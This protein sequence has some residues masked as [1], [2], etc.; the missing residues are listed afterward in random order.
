MDEAREGL[1]TVQAQRE[2]LAARVRFPWWYLAAYALGIAVI[3]AAPLATHFIPEVG[4]LVVLVA[5]GAI[6]LL[7]RMLG[8]VTGARLMRRSLRAYPSSR[9]AGITMFVVTLTATIG[10]M[11]LINSGRLGAALGV[12]ALATVLVL[13]CLIWHFRGIRRDIRGGRAASR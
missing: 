5:L 12:L 2:T 6:M 4:S 1:E 10:E 8:A 9:P 11:Q 7:D 13:G 3:L